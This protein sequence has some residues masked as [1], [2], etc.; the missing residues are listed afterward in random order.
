MY[1]VEDEWESAKLR[2]HAPPGNGK[3]VSEP[4]RMIEMGTNLY[5]CIWPLH[6]Q[7]PWGTDSRWP[8]VFC[9][10][11]TKKSMTNTCGNQWM[12][13]IALFFSRTN[14]S[15]VL[16][17]PGTPTNSVIFLVSTPP[18]KSRSKLSLKV[19]IGQQACCSKRISNAERPWLST[20]VPGAKKWIKQQ[21]EYSKID[22]S[23][24]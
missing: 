19:I 24:K 18:P 9:I 6:R 17:M 11:N 5:R 22:K 14:P 3:G 8:I 21:S 12:Q 1:R 23:Y 4:R 16:P 13:K 2:N 10:G 7:T 20:P 15:C